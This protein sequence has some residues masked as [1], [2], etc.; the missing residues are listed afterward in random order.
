MRTMLKRVFRLL[1]SP[2]GKDVTSAFLILVYTLFMLLVS[3]LP[4]V[5]GL[6][7]NI[8]LIFIIIA[9]LIMIIPA[10]Q[11]FKDKSDKAATK[12]MFA[13]F[14]YIPIVLIAWYIDKI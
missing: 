10:I 7:G 8:A 1:P 14:I 4:V 11:L 9:G 13:S 5:F 3:T 2:G 12:V 6:T